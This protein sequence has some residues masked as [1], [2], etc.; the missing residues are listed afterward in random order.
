MALSHRSA[1]LHAHDP[2]PWPVRAL[3]RIRWLR[4]GVGV[5]GGGV[6]RSRTSITIAGARMR[7]EAEALLAIGA[8]DGA[9]ARGQGVLADGRA[10]IAMERIAGGNLAEL[11]AAGPVVRS[12]VAIGARGDPRRA[13]AASHA[14]RLRHR[15][16]KP[17]N[18]VRRPD[19]SIAILDLGLAR[20]LPA[21]PDDPTRAGVRSARLST[22]RPSSCS[23]RAARSTSSADLYARSAACSTSCAAAGRRVVGD[24]S[25][26]ERA[27]AALR[28]PPLG[29]L[30]PVPGRARGLCHACLA[31]RPARHG[32][33]RGR[34]RGCAVRDQSRRTGRA[35]PL[36]VVDPARASS[37][38]CCVWAELPRVD[39][40]L[41]DML[42]SRKLAIV[43][44]RGR[45]AARR[46]GRCRAR[47]SGRRRDRRRARDLAAAGARVALPPRGA[48]RA[49][50]SPDGTRAARRCGRAAPKWLPRPPWTG[51]V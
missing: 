25:V 26:L 37:P 5:R 23:D 4:L 45:R 46:A 21:D 14:R 10:W 32:R 50:D 9:A 30:A 24:A 41:L 51:V 15:D 11:I 39:R 28:P 43:S 3:H 40:T 31:K 2:P 44:R 1:R 12:R 8:P 20:R 35:A 16:L 38:S 36:D 19:G 48:D 6:V 29:A 47:R 42:T 7:R 34:A 33:H 27:H 17:D 13:R 18:L 49:A 22:C